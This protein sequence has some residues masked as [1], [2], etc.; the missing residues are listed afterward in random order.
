MCPSSRSLGAQNKK[1]T[2][3]YYMRICLS[4]LRCSYSKNHFLA[5]H[6]SNSRNF[7]SSARVGVVEKLGSYVLLPLTNSLFAGKFHVF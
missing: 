7:K 6:L 2:Q 5:G 4:L 3:F 1:I